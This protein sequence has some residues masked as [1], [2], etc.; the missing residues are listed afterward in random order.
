MNKRKLLVLSLVLMMALTSFALGC[1]PGEEVPGND[2]PEEPAINDEDP[3][4][5]EEPDEEIELPEEPEEDDIEIEI[6]E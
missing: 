4:L 2:I 6:E 1:E 3:E 5:P